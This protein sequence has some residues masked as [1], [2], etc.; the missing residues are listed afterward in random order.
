M[1]DSYSA[2]I[3]S[4]TASFLIHHYLVGFARKYGPSCPSSIPLGATKNYHHSIG[5]ESWPRGQLLTS[6]CTTIPY[7]SL[8]SPFH[9]FVLL[10]IL[11]PNLQISQALCL[12]P[13]P[14]LTLKCQQSYTLAPPYPALQ[15]HSPNHPSL[16][17]GPTP[18][19]LNCKSSIPK[20]RSHQP[21]FHHS[22]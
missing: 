16:I 19:Y 8:H 22:N 15:V 10:S 14:P 2:T 17:S 13:S 9:K 18:Q 1:L 5:M 21:L 7:R 3:I 12:V 6:L 4:K 11:F 20:S